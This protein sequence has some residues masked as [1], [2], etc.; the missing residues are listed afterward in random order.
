MKMENIYKPFK[1]KILKIINQTYDTKVF[2]LEVDNFKYSP[3]QFVELSILGIGE[4]PISINS[5][6]HEE[7]YIDL[8]VRRV[9][10]VTNAL[11]RMEVGNH[12]W[13]RG[14]YGVGFPFEIIKGKDIVYVAGG[15]GM[16]PLKSSINH[17]IYNKGDFG[18]IT[19]LYGARTPADLL[20]KE[21]FDKWS[22]E[23]NFLVTVESTKL[24]NGG[25]SDWRGNIGLV[26]TL[27]NKL[28]YPIKDA[29]GIVC[30][31]PAMYKPVIQELKKAGMSNSS[32]Y[33]SLERRMKCGV[34]KCQHCQ[35]NNKYVCI[36]GPVFNYADIKYL[37]EA[38]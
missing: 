8:C 25:L 11:H 15:I 3:G 7:G 27:L 21:E 6:P 29:I 13:I 17:V 30:G 18:K 32:I 34:G 12:V 38:M 37:P 4:A 24:P 35:I 14:P 33:L 26:T 9:G 31:P 20:F 2:R 36:D 22:K 5:S 16:A 10:N 1:S 19:I 23:C 28:D